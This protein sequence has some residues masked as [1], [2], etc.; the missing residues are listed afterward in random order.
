MSEQI[1][2]EQTVSTPYEMF[3]RLEETVSQF[4][5]HVMR[6]GFMFKS[7]KDSERIASRLNSQTRTSLTLTLAQRSVVYKEITDPK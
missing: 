6:E 7:N 1:H 5:R 4:S 2:K 3:Q